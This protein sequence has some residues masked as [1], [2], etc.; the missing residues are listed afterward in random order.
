MDSLWIYP[1]GFFGF[2]ARR[3]YEGDSAKAWKGVQSFSDNHIKNVIRA[4]PAKSTI[5]FGADN[6]QQRQ[7]LLVCGS[8]VNTLKVLRSDTDLT[9]RQLSVGG[10][11]KAAFFVCGEFTGSWTSANGPYFGNKVLTR[12]ASKLSGCDLLIDLAHS[13]VR[14][15]IYRPPTHRHVHQLQ[16]LRFA[17]RGAAFLAHHHG[18]ETTMGRPTTDCSPHWIAYRGDNALDN[19]AAVVRIEPSDLP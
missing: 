12:P 19:V 15:T 8:S 11:L 10:G 6:S 4:H 14:R 16:M 3:F 13:R 9:Y 7:R 5:T 17:Q 1:G 18:G 2:D